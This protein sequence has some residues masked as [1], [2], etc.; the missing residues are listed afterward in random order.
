MKTKLSLLPLL[1]TLLM[2]VGFDRG[3]CLPGEAEVDPIPRTE[4]CESLPEAAC[5]V[6][7]DCRT[8]YEPGACACPACAPD[9]ETCPPCACEPSRFA[10]CTTMGPCR[11]LDEAGCAA[12]GRCSAVYEAVACSC[13]PCAEGEACPP[14]PC[15][16]PEPTFVECVD[17]GPCGGLDESACASAPGCEPEYGAPPCP[18]IGCAPGQDCDVACIQVVEY[19]G[20]HERETEPECGPVCALYCEHGNVLDDDGCPTCACNPPPPAICETDADCPGGRC[21]HLA[22]CAALGCPPPPPPRCVYD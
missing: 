11:G 7:A 21:E 12:T 19:L 1:A 18:A 20:C 10:G 2:L 5:Q 15:G 3:S 8:E 4:T 9:M 6:R 22:T 14:C 13:A 17:N 16:A